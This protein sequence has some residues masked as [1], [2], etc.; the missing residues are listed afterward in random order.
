[1]KKTYQEFAQF[2]KES[3]V[4]E[5]KTRLSEAETSNIQCLI[6][7]FEIWNLMFRNEKI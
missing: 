2:R 1:M 5:I 6:K 7:K 4:H 3:T